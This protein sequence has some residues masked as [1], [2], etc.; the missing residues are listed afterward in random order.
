VRSVNTSEVYYFGIIDILTEYN[1]AKRVEYFS[2][3]VFYCSKK[4]SCVPPD[5]YQ[6]RFLDY[7]TQ[8]FGNHVEETDNQRKT[9]KR[10]KE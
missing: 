2:K 1:C 9:I 8:R 10:Q 3:M 6:R 5:F 7:M 4:M